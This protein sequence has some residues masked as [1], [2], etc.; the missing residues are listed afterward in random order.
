MSRL[1]LSSS[2]LADLH[3][4][5]RLKLRCC[6]LLLGGLVQL[7]KTSRRSLRVIT[8]RSFSQSRGDLRGL[9]QRTHY[10]AATSWR[11]RRRGSFAL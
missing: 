7:G 2:E 4:P 11:F 3:F 1:I 9:P 8:H 10:D 6:G 5:L